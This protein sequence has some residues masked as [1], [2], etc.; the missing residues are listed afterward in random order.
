MVGQEGKKQ[1]DLI[2]GQPI[3]LALPIY[4]ILELVQ[5]DTQLK[6]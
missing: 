1:C 2:S 4:V 5:H 6:L 3:A